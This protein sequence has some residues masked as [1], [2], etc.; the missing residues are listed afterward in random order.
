ME[1]NNENKVGELH[2]TLW[3][4]AKAQLYTIEKK[5]VKISTLEYQFL[6]YGLFLSTNNNKSNNFYLVGAALRRST[7]LL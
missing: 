1:E 4:Y 7:V 6:Q 5:W 3:N 2:E